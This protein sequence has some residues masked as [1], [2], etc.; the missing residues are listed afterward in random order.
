MT[1][2]TAGGPVSLHDLFTLAGG[3][4]QNSTD[5]NEDS[6][7]FADDIFSHPSE[8]ELPSD[9]ITSIGVSPDNSDAPIRDITAHLEEHANAQSL[10]N[11]QKE[12]DRR[13][14]KR[15]RHALYKLPSVISDSEVP[16]LILRIRSLVLKRMLVKF[17][18]ADGSAHALWRVVLILLV[19]GWQKLGGRIRGSLRASWVAWIQRYYLM[20]S[21]N[22]EK[23]KV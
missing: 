15:R 11:P 22:N 6:Y 10:L 18:I 12:L 7:G 17:Q 2:G 23:S 5:G 13:Q 21:G 19:A 16:G 20:Q 4:D 14:Q 9:N 8:H 3:D 1:M